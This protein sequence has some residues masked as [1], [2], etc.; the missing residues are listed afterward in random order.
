MTELLRSQVEDEI[1]DLIARVRDAPG[2]DVGIVIPH[3][4]RAFQTPLNARLLLQFGRQAGKRTA[5]VSEDSQVQQLARM[6]GFPTFASVPAFEHGVEM[7]MAQQPQP[8]RALLDDGTSA[9]AVAPPKPPPVET[10]AAP[11]RVAGAPPT[12]GP[13]SPRIAPTGMSPF[14]ETPRPHNR[15]ALYFVAAGVAL[16][17]VILFLLLSPSATITMTVA[18]TPLSVNPTI[19]GSTDQSAASQGDHLLTQVANATT[20]NAF[21]ATPT[22]QQ[23]LPATA[24]SGVETI[25]SQFPI[26]GIIPAGTQFE[27]SDPGHTTVFGVTAGTYI[28]VG[29][30]GPPSGCAE[31]PNANL[32]IKAESTGSSGNV[33][34]GILT[35]WPPTQQPTQCMAQPGPSL[36]SAT[37]AQAASGGADQKQV[38]VASSTDV[39]NWNQQAQQLEDQM[40]TQLKTELQSKAPGQTLAIDPA[41]NGF[42]VTCTA[43]P[44]VPAVNAQFSPQQIS[45]TCNATGVFYDPKAV[46]RDVLADLQGQVPQGYQLAQGKL[47][48]QPV[49]VT[50]AGPDGTVILSASAADYSQPTVNVEGLKG[51][52]A[53]KSPGDAQRIISGRIDKVQSVQVSEFPFGLPYLPF[54][55]SRITIDENF[56]PLSPSS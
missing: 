31:S 23:A 15:R 1:A 5:I 51:Q 43:A 10:S 41:K 27:S 4:S 2:D 28:C 48:M 9:V 18:A 46:K 19:Q 8:V 22:G 3:G 34:A 47:T 20:Q 29:P 55:G 45:I 32:P 42:N 33:S 11:P 50:Q 39:A 44:P 24:A 38:T 40:N 13:R 52:L 25:S 6:S 53:G 56:V 37:N 21:Q 12:G 17:G 14:D 16:L 36:C 49:V 54:F 26:Q 30:N 7:K 35:Y